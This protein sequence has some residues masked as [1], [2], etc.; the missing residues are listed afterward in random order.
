MNIRLPAIKIFFILLLSLSFQVV[1]SEQADKPTLVLGVQTF[2][3]KSATLYEWTPIVDHLNQQLRSVKLELKVFFLEELNQAVANKQVDF[4]LSNPQA[5][6]NLA[7]TQ[8]LSSPL[9]SLMNLVDNQPVRMFGG[10]IATR[11]DASHINTF[12]DIGRKKIA[13]PTTEG[14]GGFLMQKR[15]L[16]NHGIHI[17]PSQVKTTGSQD[18]AIFTLLE[19]NADIAFV[20]TGV[21]E[22]LTQAGRIPPD[23]IKVL[24]QQPGHT[25]PLILSTQLY[26]EW[27]LSA[28]D[29]VDMFY[30]SE[31][32]AKF[33]AIPYGHSALERANIYGFSIPIDY[34][35]IRQLMIELNVPPYDKT[36]TALMTHIINQHRMTINIG[37]FTLVLFIIMLAVILFFNYRLKRSND[38]LIERD[39]D[40]R[41]AAVAFETQKAIMITDRFEQ[42]IRVNYAFSEITGF[43]SD[44]VM[45]KTPSILRSR[46]H[47]KTFY[48]DVWPQ[49]LTD[50]SW[51]GEVCSQR[52]N[53]QDFPTF[54]VI[55]AIK[56][57]QNE[58]THFLFAFN[59]I[60]E[61]KR[62]EQSFFELAFYDPLTG[63]A[64]RRLLED[65][66]DKALAAAERHHHF[67]ALMFIDLDHFKNLNDSMGHN[68]G[69]ELLKRVA[70]RLQRC[71]RK[72]DVVA[73]PGGDEFIILMQNLSTEESEAA[74]QA[75][76]IANKIIEQCNRAYTL[77]GNRYTIT[78]S[79]GI[80]LF[81]SGDHTSIELMKRSDL[82]MYQAKEQGRNAVRFFDPDMEKKVEN[83]SQLEHD[84]RQ[85]IDNRDFLLYYQKKVN[86]QQDTQGYEALIRWPHP[87]K[88]MI[89]P[90]D[91]IPVAEETGLII[92]I[93]DWVIEQACQTLKRFQQNDQT[94]ALTLSI[95]VS[96]KQFRQ[97]DFTDKVIQKIKH[98]QIDPSK[99]ELEVTESMLM[100]NLED[101][102]AKMKELKTLGV[103]FSL[104]DFG[105]GYSSLSYLKNLPLSALKVD[106]SF[107]RDML[108]D[109]EDA[110]IVETI[111]ALAK[112]LK[113][114]VI[115]EGVEEVAQV[116]ALKLLG[117]DLYQGFLYSKPQPLD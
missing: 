86:A 13:A 54:Q 38:Q 49:I 60:S 41:I 26:P 5:Y 35:Q 87:E 53:G 59:D 94:K 84:L 77:S 71:V 28:L 89:S 95:N 17:H 30:A 21:I 91:F 3:D 7:V 67:C 8:G 43:S 82:A 92:P 39:A 52:K 24:G 23:S 61:Q 80:H 117:C 111:I 76:S 29:H 79:L 69:D 108:V 18:L 45:G 88:N 6:I 4:I 20:R 110:A 113:L 83:R 2:T 58:I 32:T 66:I 16:R 34:E 15:E 107:V 104:D 48:A 46:K 70:R 37:V 73:R 19:G 57:N 85:A 81:S 102:V 40:L 27:P 12:K 112:T 98:Y 22:S 90:A 96:I 9:A 55:N 105:T 72:E 115:A 25:F 14:F 100:D 101:T 56:N 64:N 33:L 93:G 42:I 1:A 51:Q 75:L 99:L 109:K 78:A 103:Q 62:T 97:A 47:N 11:Q 68:F 63:L 36:G 44:E 114:Q 74:N 50:G 10:I 106:K 31:V 65:H 116:E